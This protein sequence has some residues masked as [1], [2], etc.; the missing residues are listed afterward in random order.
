MTS[1]NFFAFQKKMMM[2]AKRSMPAMR[3][4]W[5]SAERIADFATTMETDGALQ[6]MMRFAL[7]RPCLCAALQIDIQNPVDHEQRAL[8]TTYLA[9]S[10]G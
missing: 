8:D 6:R 9:Q 3:Q 5:P 4:C 7:V 2:A 10:R 1:P